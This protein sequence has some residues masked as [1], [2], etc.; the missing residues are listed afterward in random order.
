[1]SAKRS[2]S[3]RP[4]PGS[5]GKLAVK[6]ALMLGAVGVLCCVVVGVVVFGK[7]SSV[8]EVLSETQRQNFTFS[9]PM[10]L[11][12]G[13]L[14]G[15]G[16][17]GA[18]FALGNGLASRVTDLSLAVSKM[19]RGSKASVRVTGDDE[20]SGL[21][22]ALSSLANDLASLEGGGEGE[23]GGGAM[24]S[25]DPQVREM[26]DR[27]LPEQ[28]CAPPPGWEVDGALL[29]GSRGG[30]EYYDIH[31]GEDEAIL[32]LIGCEGQSTSAV[33]AARLA[34]DEIMRALAQGV[35][36]RK[37][38]AHSN[39][40]L[41]KTLARGVCASATL[42][43]VRGK[44]AKI[45]QAGARVPVILCAAG[46]LEDLTAEGIALG[47]DAGPVFEKGLKSQAVEM[48]S[49]MRLVLVNDA[50][51]RDETLV[52]AVQEHSPKHTMPFMNM[53]LGSVEQNAGDGGLREDVLLL[54]A[55]CS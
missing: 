34:R 1:M 53:V 40:V 28:S 8:L 37:A 11:L 32:V 36:P 35:T 30:T 52:A 17:A 9:M 10:V 18:A 29:A 46:E 16:V 24:A 31:S 48:G 4:R 38:L 43:Q 54:T 39:R 14:C 45:Y 6:L 19:G 33:F 55:K 15:L 13:G 3:S 23:S 21:G 42:V 47:L 22:R 41:H 49:G 12:I 25:Y 5:N 44:E 27:A 7:Y 51:N 26:R 50:G 2:R 20:L